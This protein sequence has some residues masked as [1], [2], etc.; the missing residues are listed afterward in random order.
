MFVKPTGKL[1]EW[2]N[3]RNA[4]EAHV[5]LKLTDAQVAM[6]PALREQAAKQVHLTV[7]EREDWAVWTAWTHTGHRLDP[8]L[9]QREDAAVNALEQAT[10]RLERLT[11]AAPAAPPSA[12]SPAWWTEPYVYCLF[13]LVVEL[14][15][16]IGRS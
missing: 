2:L 15:I 10:E 14:A 16:L 12:T 8:L 7:D 1:L 4:P 6:L 9:R 11:V 5:G 13:T 3:S